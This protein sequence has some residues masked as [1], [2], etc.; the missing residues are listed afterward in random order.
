M[1]YIPIV[2]ILL[3]SSLSGCGNK[4]A[5]P[6]NA[7]TG[8][9]KLHN[10]SSTPHKTKENNIRINALRDTALSVGARGGLAWRAKQINSILSRQEHLLYRIFN[11]HCLLLDDNILPPVLVSG[12]NI[13]QLHGDGIIRIADQSY[14]IIQQ[15]KFVTNPP[16][17]R[18]YLWMHFSQPETPNRTLLPQNKIE[19]AIWQKHV[20]VGWLS[21]IKQADTIF[22]SNLGRLKRDYQGI[23]RYHNLLAQHIVSKPFVAKASFGITGN[24]KEISINDQLLRITDFPSLQTDS[25]KWQT[26]IFVHD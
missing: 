22:T 9:K 16:T 4:S 23:I 26:E 19:R 1:K 18:K 24:G 17:W 5:I 21:G 20:A 6:S 10:L 13:L 15:A 12:K 2:I 7:P 8:L 14:R 25:S 11:F 3:A